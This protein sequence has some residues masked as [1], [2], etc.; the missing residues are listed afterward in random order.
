[1]WLSSHPGFPSGS[2]G[3][4]SSC[5]TETICNA[6]D[7]GSIPGSRR[8]SGEGNGNPLSILAGKSHGQ[9][10][11]VGYSPWGCKRVGCKLT[12]KQ[13]PPTCWD[14]RFSF[15]IWKDWTSSHTV[16]PC[17]L[18]V[19]LLQIP[20]TANTKGL[21]YAQCYPI[22]YKAFEYP[23]IWVSIEDCWSQSLAETEGW[24]ILCHSPSVWNYW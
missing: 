8:S 1:M 10:S 19:S 12:I 11:L 18:W 20:L 7:S 4:E 5:N 21:L 16:G 17:S 23:W 6:R 15:E 22:L 24:R 9:R 13:T 3:K 14:S 2:M